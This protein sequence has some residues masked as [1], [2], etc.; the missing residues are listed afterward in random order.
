MV[1]GDNPCFIIAEIGIN[2][3]GKYEQA[4]ALI[5]VAAKAGCNVAKFQLFTAERMYAKKAGKYKTASGKKRDI[6]DIVREGELPPAW[7]PKL[8]AYANQKGLEFFATVC[9]EQGADILMQ[10][11]V[12]GYKFASYEITHIPLFR[13]VTKAKKPI[14]L[15]TGGATMREVAE[16]ME[17]LA[18]QKHND[19]LLNHCNGEY[20]PKLSSLNLAVI[21]TLQ[22]AFP[23]AVIGFSDN[24]SD[25]S[26]GVA[27]AAVALGAKA[28]EAH[29]TLDRTLPGPDHSFA[30]NPKELAQTVRI[31]RETER[32]I[33]KGK[34]IDVDSRM[35][36]TSERKTFEGEAYVRKFAYRCLFTK[37]A[38]KKG[39]KFTKK[40]IAVLRPGKNKR[41][42]EPKYYELLLKGF[43]AS[44][45]IPE[46]KSIQWEDVLTK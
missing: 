19:T 45:A 38:I 36:G 9:D 30:L 22:F 13:Y 10:N 44:R 26:L 40:N 23:Y 25:P 37:T 20:P 11:N 15:S 14:V 33:Q 16:T 28:Y 3:D 39:E 46:N 1:G 35:L 42:L 7:I 41:G 18:D 43:R 6:I 5:D 21:K 31:I 24:G 2:F 12:D 8:K 27:R 29:I 32:E 34:T 4:L 17:V